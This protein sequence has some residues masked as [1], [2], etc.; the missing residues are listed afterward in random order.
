M[1]SFTSTKEFRNWRS[2]IKGSVGFVPTMGA[3]HKGH[4]SLV[5]RALKENDFAVA[6][7]FVNPAQFGKNEDFS[8]YPRTLY[9]D[10]RLLE[11][12]GCSVLFAPSAEE[13]YPNGFNTK[14]TADHVLSN[15]LCGKSRPGHF[16]GVCLVVGKLF[17]IVL[18]EKAYFGLK[19]YQQVNI[20]KKMVKDLDFPLE[21]V[22][23]TTVREKDG[24][25]M[26]SRNAFLSQEER[27]K[28][29]L[30]YASL[31]V[32]RNLFSK[33]EKSPQLLSNGIKNSLSGARI[34][35]DYVEIV[36]P[37]TLQP[38][39]QVAKKGD[40]IALAAFLGKT[41]LIDNIEI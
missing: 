19:D 26:S 22:P 4:I 9:S 1:Q 14:I 3:L 29:P 2:S 12:A 27:K 38:V 20:V 16:D 36:N 28:A 40:V 6:S 15:N 13:I 23:C 10:K 21:I 25:A 5:E 11:A 7:V 30:I 33:G 18:P 31:K 17:N 39:T 37:S 41:R 35:I 24:L 32:A 8:K 34:A